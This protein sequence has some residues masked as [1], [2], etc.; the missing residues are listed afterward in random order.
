MTVMAGW[1]AGQFHASPPSLEDLPKELAS[2]IEINSSVNSKA[3]TVCLIIF[4][5]CLSARSRP[6]LS[7]LPVK[8]CSAAASGCDWGRGWSVERPGFRLVALNPVKR[9]HQVGKY[10]LF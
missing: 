4:W 8:S 2:A 6:Q 10:C 5:V 9:S 7:R 3:S 1:F